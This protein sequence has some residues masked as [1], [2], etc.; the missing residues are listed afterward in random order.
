M[1]QD[2]CGKKK[3]KNPTKN[4]LQHLSVHD[5]KEKLKNIP[6]KYKMTRQELCDILLKFGIPNSVSPSKSMG[7]IK[8]DGNNSCYIDTMIFSLIHNKNKY[9]LNNLFKSEI[10]HPSQK[11]ITI[12]E[13]IRD[14]IKY[15]YYNIHGKKPYYIYC[16]ILRNL[17]D[18]FDKEY[19]KV[20]K[21]E[22]I[23]W[24]D[25]QQEPNDVSNVLMR[26]FNIK[27]EVSIHIKTPTFKRREK[28]FFNNTTINVDVLLENSIIKLKDYIPLTTDSFTKENGSVYIKTVEITKSK[29]LQINIIRNFLNEKKIKSSIIPLE[30][31]DF[32][33][34]KLNCTSILIHNGSSPNSGHYT[35]VFK[36]YKDDLWYLYDDL[37]TDYRLMGSFSDTLKW[38]D[39][40]IKKNLVS[41]I[42]T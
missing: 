6:N 37:K 1:Q 13:N 12:A 19:N 42:Y 3:L 29:F 2:P 38:K 32:K 22:M 27:P 24:I 23:D 30:I 36:N 21:I 41:C 11:L 9:I 7:F 31:L 4:T 34:K 26:V 15:I 33:N 28:V 10:K 16:T 8:Y 14:S 17:F 40:Y 18:K 39:G 5:M 25:D 35:C 20:N